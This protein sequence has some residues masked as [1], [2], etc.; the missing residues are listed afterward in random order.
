MRLEEV[1]RPS[2]LAKYKYTVVSKSL[3]KEI[4]QFTLQDGQRF[5]VSFKMLSTPESHEIYH[6]LVSYVKN[7]ERLNNPSIAEQIRKALGGIYYVTFQDADKQDE[8]YEMTNKNK[9]MF[10]ILGHVTKIIIDF[11]NTHKVLEL[12]FAAEGDELSRIKVY[13]RLS[14]ILPK[15]SNLKLLDIDRDPSITSYIFTGK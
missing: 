5:I 14:V 3:Y 6:Q 11:S 15:Y 2:D 13:D 4:Y 12:S 8:D 9:D 7:P 1:L 10:F